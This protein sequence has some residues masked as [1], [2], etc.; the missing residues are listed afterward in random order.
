[1]KNGIRIGAHT[2]G[3]LLIIETIITVFGAL[4]TIEVSAVEFDTA[5]YEYDINYDGNVGEDE[6]GVTITG[7]NNM[8][9]LEIVTIPAEIDGKPVFALGLEGALYG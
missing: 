9:N 4:T 8:G 5:P 2:Y 6:K 7:F 1:M 3:Y